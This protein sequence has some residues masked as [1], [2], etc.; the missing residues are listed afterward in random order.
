VGFDTLGPIAPGLAVQHYPTP[1]DGYAA[2]VAT[3]H[4]GLYP[5]VVQGLMTNNAALVFSPQGRAELATWGG[6][7]AYPD[8]I[9]QVYDD[10]VPVPRQYYDVAAPSVLGSPPAPGTAAGAA[11][12][13]RL[14]AWIE[15]EIHG[16]AD[17][18]VHQL[19]VQA[20]Q[21]ASQLADQVHQL[22][23]ANATLQRRLALIAHLATE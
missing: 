17:G 23:Q 3:L 4:N 12:W 6:D 2:T 20:Q 19:L 1:A 21:Q 18:S 16:S 9:Q 13:Q 11:W 10:L 8:H 14:D 5:V 15:A 22:Q 7:A